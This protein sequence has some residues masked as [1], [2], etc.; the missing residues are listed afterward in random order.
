MATKE[1]I[2][3]LLKDGVINFKDDQVKDA[4]QEAVDAGSSALEMIM[5]GL[6]AGMEVV[7]EL[8]D[9]Q[10]YFVPE[11]LMCAD[12]L[13][14]GLDILRPNVPKAGGLKGQVVIGVWRATCTT[15]AR[16]WSR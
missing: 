1:E 15:S 2:L 8:Y 7:G 12:A 13:Y 11:V 3:E 5:D 10:E 16:T 4:A 6:A 9:S 14:A